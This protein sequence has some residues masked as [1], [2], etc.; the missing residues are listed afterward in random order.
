MRGLLGAAWRLKP[1]AGAEVVP[2]AG[3]LIIH[4]DHRNRG[5][6]VLLHRGTAATAKEKG[7]PAMISVSGNA[8]A[9]SLS[10]AAGWREV[11]ELERIYLVRAQRRK[12]LRSRVPGAR[13]VFSKARGLARRFGYQM[14]APPSGRLVDGIVHP[15]GGVDKHVAVSNHADVEAMSELAADVGRHTSSRSSQYLRW[16][17]RNPDRTYRFVYWKDF[18]LR[19]YMILAWKGRGLGRTMIVDHCSTDDTVFEDMLSAV[20]RI[21]TGKI[22]MMA[23]T[24]PKRRLELARQL[25]FCSDPDYSHGRRRRFLMYPFADGDADTP[26]SSIVSAARA[27]RVDLID[28]MLG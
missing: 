26:E 5:L 19:G 13:R 1:G 12:P 16:R 23:S 28:T 9:Q 14:V 2:H 15:V 3:E 25:G 7:F 21:R 27:W 24:L 6:F 22:E 11:R 18:D 8:V 20:A 10:L 17:V 4:P